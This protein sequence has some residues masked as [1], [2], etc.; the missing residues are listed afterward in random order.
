MTI[1][2]K[3]A[4][5]AGASLALSVVGGMVAWFSVTALGSR[6]DDAIGTN[7]RKLELISD[8]RANVFTFRLQERGILLFS[9]INSAEQ[10]AACRDA[11][12]K[13]VAS[14][15]AT[16]RDI[17]PLIQTQAGLDDINHVEAGIQEYKAHQLEVRAL[18]AANQVAEATQWDRKMLVPA[19][20]KIVK[21]LSDL[22][23]TVHALNLRVAESGAGVRR[24]AR[25]LVLL[26][27][28]AC[29][30]IGFAVAIAVSRVTRQLHN[31]AEALRETAGQVAGAASQIASSSQSVAESASE[32]AASLEET[33]AASNEINSMA[34]QNTASCQSAAVTVTRARQGFASA[35][36]TL[37]DM[38]VAMRE[39]GT[40]SDK[41]S[42][43]IK[44]IDEIA[45]QT[46]ILAL[47]AAVEAARAGDAGLGFAVV[48]DEVRN[49]AQRCTQAASETAALIE[50]SISKSAVGKKKVDEV[51]ASIHALA[52]ESGEVKSLVDQVYTGSQEQT[53][54]MDQIAR[55]IGEMQ[56]VTQTAA[57]G[58]E[59]SA[60]AAG[61]LTAQV[62][63]LRGIVEEL[64]SMVGAR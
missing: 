34:R 35:S 13:A 44:V 57:A 12:D 39:I 33:S 62:D 51:A 32:Q 56:D 42:K 37:D 2:R 9:H 47:N 10:V 29:L 17:R 22:N 18:L 48:A 55:A 59:E 7:S 11:Y 38:I 27:L 31:T 36:K 46:N 52:N 21:G 28:L 5:C 64:R 25:L 15:F 4:L 60:S 26:C 6:L 16:I 20:G 1:G 41:I 3:I 58:A 14:A 8:L 50:D 24:T 19:G 63:A 61:E 53:R 49:L 54:G 30:P 45:F 43:I 23:Q 40:S